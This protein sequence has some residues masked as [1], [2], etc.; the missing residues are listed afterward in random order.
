MHLL[1]LHMLD[2]RPDSTLVKGQYALSGIQTGLGGRPPLRGA[3]AASSTL[4]EP[5]QTLR[6][7]AVALRGCTGESPQL[8]FHLSSR[9]VLPPATGSP[10][11]PPYIQIQYLTPR[12]DSAVRHCVGP[13]PRFSS[14]SGV[15]APVR[16]L[17]TG[18]AFNS[19]CTPTP[20]LVTST[21]IPPNCFLPLP[22]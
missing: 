21:S 3:G 20:A 4:R 9:Q 19:P 18:V 11:Y 8:R 10:I 15:P 2:V 1:Q 7:P 6:Y 14:S 16:M 5:A 13:H 17:S 12:F 22:Q